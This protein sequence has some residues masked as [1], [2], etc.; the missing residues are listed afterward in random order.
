VEG[1][2]TSAFTV[3]TDEP[4]S[5]GTFEWDATTI[6]V[7]EAFGGGRS[8]LGYTYG[9]AALGALVDGT[10]SA[11]VRRVRAELDR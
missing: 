10:L 3:P 5:D 2:V 7:V 6:V 4:E 11:A 9:P 8:G 1:V